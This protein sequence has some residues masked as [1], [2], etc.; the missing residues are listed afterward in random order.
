[1][2]SERGAELRVVP[3]PE[4]SD[5]AEIVVA[6]GQEAFAKLIDA[7]LSVPEFRLRRILAKADLGSTS[8]RDNALEDAVAIVADARAGTAL[9]GVLMQQVQNQFDIP[10]SALQQLLDQPRQAPRRAVQAPS[11][12]TPSAEDEEPAAPRAATQAIRAIER[13]EL[14]FFAMCVREPDLGEEFVRQLAD[15][16][17]SSP[18]MQRVRD[19]LRENLRDPL[20]NLDSGDP[21]L[22]IRVTEVTLLADKEPASKE[23]LKFS[24]LQLDLRRVERELRLAQERSDFDLQRQL[25]AVRETVRKEIADLMGQTA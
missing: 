14:A 16:H 8:G 1:M 24:F 20:A 21:D 4:G 11:R 7:A 9:R 25:W 19:H 23:A 2:T 13:P 3:V 22:G 18:L 10:S 6:G 15:G 12:A 17:L 5:P